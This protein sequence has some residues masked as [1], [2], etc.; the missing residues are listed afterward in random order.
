MLIPLAGPRSDQV[1]GWSP[2]LKRIEGRKA[3]KPGRLVICPMDLRQAGGGLR[4][5]RCH[6]DPL[7]AVRG[8]CGRISRRRGHLS[9]SLCHVVM[10][11]RTMA[12]MMSTLGV[13]RHG[14]GMC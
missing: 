11:V 3:G 6:A 8:V 2:M 9:L 10:C 14:R 4:K 1:F 12:T 5:D 7:T 13:L